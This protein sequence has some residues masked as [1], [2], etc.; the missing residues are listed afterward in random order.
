[1]VGNQVRFGRPGAGPAL[2]PQAV[3]YTFA[4]DYRYLRIYRGAYQRFRNI[5]YTIWNGRLY[6]GPY[7]RLENLVFT[8]QGDI[9][10]ILPL[11]PILADGAY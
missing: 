1:V 6:R 5:A 9:N 3:A 8:S 4:H 2:G 11:L 10:E 7:P